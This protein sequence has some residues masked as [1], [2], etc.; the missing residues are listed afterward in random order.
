MVEYTCHYVTFAAVLESWNQ[1]N[2]IIP[3]IYILE[4]ASKQ[5]D[6]KSYPTD[7][8]TT[9]VVFPFVTLYLLLVMSCDAL[10]AI[11]GGPLRSKCIN[12]SNN[13]IYV[14]VPKSLV[15]GTWVVKPSLL[16]FGTTRK[17]SIPDMNHGV[18]SVRNYVCVN[19]V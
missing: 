6:V 16:L 3:S 19:V 17:L 13:S 4:K 10:G 12:P 1:R 9:I 15:R 8:F 14:A 18:Y 5:Q 2:F 7:L 11:K